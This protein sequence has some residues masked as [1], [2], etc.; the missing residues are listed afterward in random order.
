[1]FIALPHV[2]DEVMFGIMVAVGLAL[3]K[4]PLG[5]P[6]KW[7]ETFYHEFSH[8]MVCLL[9]GGKIDRIELNFDGSGCCYTRG[10]WRIPTLMAGYIGASVWGGA[11]Y[12][13]GWLLSGPDGVAWIRVEL[14][15]LAVVFLFYARD[16]W[17]IVILLTLGGIYTWAMLMPDSRLLPL[18]LQFMG[19]YVMLNAIRAPLFL[20]DGQHKGDGA[21]LA[22]IFHVLPEGFWIA[23]WWMIALGVMF[24]CMVLTL[25]QFA[26][27]AAP[28]L[29]WLG[30]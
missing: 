5:W 18:L 4:S 29:R 21:M 25:P 23:L 15:I 19:I 27:W 13:I 30:V 17:T 22:D 28:F 24:A 2:S 16:L 12:M 14:A 20:I 3:S 10:G 6:L 7:A 11:L 26:Q 1:M 8:G 9:T